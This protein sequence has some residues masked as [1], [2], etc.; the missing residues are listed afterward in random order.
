MNHRGVTFVRILKAGMQNFIRNAT[1]A[2]AA[3]AVMVITLS[4]ILFSV[5]A[6][7]TFNNTIQQINDKIDISVYLED[8]VTTEQKDS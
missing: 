6:N 7:A 3:I 5:I 2:I 1:L 8:D 4:I